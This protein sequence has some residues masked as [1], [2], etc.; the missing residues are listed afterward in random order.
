MRVQCVPYCAAIALASSLHGANYSTDFENPPFPDPPGNVAG[1]DG[2]TINDI[3]DASSPLAFILDWNNGVTPQSH[4]AGLGGFYNSPSEDTVLLTHASGL[5]IGGTAVSF[6]FSII[7]STNDFADRDTFGLS[8]TNGSDNLF[9]LFFTPATQT[10][11]PDGDT[12]AQWD[13]SYSTGLS[14]PIAFV[15]GEGVVESGTY[16]LSLTFTPNGASTDFSLTIASQ[17]NSETRTGTIPVDPLTVAAN[18]NLLWAPIGGAESSGDNFLIV[19]DLAVVPEPA[20]VAAWM[21]LSLAGF[22]LVAR[23]RRA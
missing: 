20:S 14:G 16:S 7:D 15:P 3:N 10:A 9:S 21:L 23:R 11:N 6:L 13:L 12:D 22:S 8:L 5:N 4:A 17:V 19:D 2:W 18:F 1:S